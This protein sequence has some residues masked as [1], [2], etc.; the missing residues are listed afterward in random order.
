MMDNLDILIAIIVM[1]LAN[2]ATRLF[3]FLF[4]V[5]R[6]PPAFIIFVEK[7]GPIFIFRALVSKTSEDATEGSCISNPKLKP[8]LFA[9]K[10][11]L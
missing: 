9:P 7:G 1:S 11:G 5:S 8:T 4:F 3:P 10:R 2:F 6:E